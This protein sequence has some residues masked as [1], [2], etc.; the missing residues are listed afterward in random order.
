[1]PSGSGIDPEQ[2]REE[3][4]R[5]IATLARLRLD[6]HE[7]ARMTQHLGAILGY[8]AQLREL[9]T[10]AIKPMTHTMP[11]DYPERPNQ[12]QPTLPIDKALTNTPQREG[13]FFQVPR[14]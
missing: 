8:V 14:I 10:S 3:E 9:D 12:V 5:E 1:M 2:I 7:V 13:H 6:D 4:V 11:F